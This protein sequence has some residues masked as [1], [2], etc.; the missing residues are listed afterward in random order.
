MGVDRSDNF[1]LYVTVTF[2]VEVRRPS[3]KDHHSPARFRCAWLA[4][5]FHLIKFSRAKL[6]TFHS[7][8]TNSVPA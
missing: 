7:Q 8:C 2:G 3:G 6:S 5:I 1:C 4:L